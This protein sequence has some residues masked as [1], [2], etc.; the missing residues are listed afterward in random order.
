[1]ELKF[2]NKTKQLYD[3]FK[4]KIDSKYMRLEYTLKG[5]DKINEKLETTSPYK[6]TTDI[7][8][9]FLNQ[10]IE[11]D[12]FKPI[13]KYIEESGK[14]L[15]K[16][17]RNI[18]KQRKRGFI[19]EFAHKSNARDTMIFD[20]EQVLDIVKKDTN[21]DGNYSRYKKTICDIVSD[22]L[23]DNFKKLKEFKQKF[24]VSRS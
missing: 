18:K 13:Q 1:M 15:N 17:Y 14:K 2:Y 10:S 11:A 20:V 16:M 9:N 6:L 3:A 8:I 22:D 23:K 4:I 21:K 24:S 7:L 5:Y 19:R 12:V